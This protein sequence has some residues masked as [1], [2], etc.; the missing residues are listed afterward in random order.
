M[1][2]SIELSVRLWLNFG[3]LPSEPVRIGLPLRESRDRIY[4]A[5]RR[6]G[7]PPGYLD[8]VAEK[9]NDH[10]SSSGHQAFKRGARFVLTLT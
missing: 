1:G 8:L 7:E 4:C 3:C 5:F 2:R 10:S 9:A 6:L